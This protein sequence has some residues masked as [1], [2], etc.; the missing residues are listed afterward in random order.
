MIK[1]TN[2]SYQMLDNTYNNF[3][4]MFN[5]A[6]S[7]YLAELLYWGCLQEVYLR[8]SYLTGS[9]VFLRQGR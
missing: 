7:F 9:S 8:N 3:G 6:R 1:K 5:Q 2:H 4:N